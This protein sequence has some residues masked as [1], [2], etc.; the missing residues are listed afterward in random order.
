MSAEESFGQY[1][2]LS[3]GR[4]THGVP[5]LIAA[6]NARA[7]AAMPSLINRWKRGDQCPAA[8][9]PDT[10]FAPDYGIN[11][12]R[13]Q[14]NADLVQAFRCGVPKLNCY[15]AT[16]ANDIVHIP[17]SAIPEG[18]VLCSLRDVPAQYAERAEALIAS[19]AESSADAAVAAVLMHDGIY[20]RAEK[21]VKI[22]KPVQV[23][24]LF[25]SPVSM[26]TPR[27][28]VID[29]QPGAELKVLLCDHSQSPGVE[30]LSAEIIAAEVADDASLELYDIEE[31]SASTHRNRRVAI[32]QQHRSHLT[33][34]SL[35][36]NGGTSL[37]T[38]SIDAEGNDTETRINGLA[39]CTGTQTVDNDIVL[40][41]NGLRGMSRQLFKYTLSDDSHGVFGGKVVVEEGATGTDAA[42]TDRNLLNSPSA[43][44]DAAPQLEIYCDEVK[45][46]HGATT[47]RLD[48]RALFYM[49]SRGIP[50]E[51]A[52]RMLTQ[53][54]MADVIDNISY[55][56]LR[57]RLH[58]LVEKRLSGAPASCESCGVA[59]HPAEL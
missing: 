56:V 55:D 30:H 43:R 41:H 25:R 52:R 49:Q 10:V 21:G 32:R 31:S 51:E 42:Q 1:A 16:V 58:I 27:C 33:V 17:E 12:D 40:R 22:E 2:A 19:V 7:L 20:I 48:E 39:I 9:S 3:Q 18:L 53:A 11:L 34:A 14:M 46:S 23:V 50:H 36:L 6:V 47:G 4:H 38:Y 26:L 37:N 24:N 5:A 28:V 45:C 15:L 57:Q 8:C 54:F 44:M 29:V 59:C 35:F 13:L